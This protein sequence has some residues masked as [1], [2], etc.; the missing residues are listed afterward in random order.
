MASYVLKNNYLVH[1]ERKETSL[2]AKF[3]RYIK[4]NQNMIIVGML[5]MGSNNLDIFSK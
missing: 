4:E 5:M 3:K 2:F 1:S